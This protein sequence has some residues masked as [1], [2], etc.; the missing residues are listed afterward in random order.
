MSVKQ[1]EQTVGSVEGAQPRFQLSLR[2]ISILLVIF[3]LGISGY[4][5]YVKL[6]DV[7]M[8]CSANGAFDCGAVQGSVYSELGGIPIAW[9]GFAVNILMLTILLLEPRVEFLRQSGN[10]VMLLFGIVLFAAL[11]SVYLIYIQG[12][13]LQAWCMWCLMHEA[14]IFILFGV[15]LWRVIVILSKTEVEAH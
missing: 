13:V 11:Y 14:Y 9:M 15:T 4:L 7:P 8:V 10:G 3:G 2:L 12:V 1:A 6:T 5:S